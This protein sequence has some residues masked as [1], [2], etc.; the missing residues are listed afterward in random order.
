MVP[1][2]RENATRLGG[3]LQV[4]TSARDS[5]AALFAQGLTPLRLGTEEEC[6][7]SPRPVWTGRG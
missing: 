6:N 3:R 1:E 7:S 5:F 4:F 2:L